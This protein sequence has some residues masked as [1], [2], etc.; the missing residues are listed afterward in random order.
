VLQEYMATERIV[1]E[2][3]RML[4]PFPNISSGAVA[5]VMMLPVAG[6]L[7]DSARARTAAI[8][9]WASASQ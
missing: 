7:T 9:R 8:T 5:G 3:W 4:Q 2:P 6:R 1:E